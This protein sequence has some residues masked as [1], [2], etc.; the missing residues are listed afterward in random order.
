MTD[1]QSLDLLQRD[2][3]PV[4]SKF[5]KELL[6]ITILLVIQQIHQPKELPH[7]V[8]HGGTCASIGSR[9]ADCANL[10]V[11]TNHRMHHPARGHLHSS[12]QRQN[13]KLIDP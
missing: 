13:V 8:L 1:L 9:V 4:P 12:L 5:L 7:V 6:L 2:G 10:A 3:F 11:S